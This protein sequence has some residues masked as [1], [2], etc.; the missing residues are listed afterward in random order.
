MTLAPSGA[1]SPGLPFLGAFFPINL[2]VLVEIESLQES[3]FHLG[4]TILDT[5]STVILLGH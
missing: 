1:A 3:H 2:A 4:T 5:F